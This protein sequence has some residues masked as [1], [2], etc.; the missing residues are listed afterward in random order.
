MKLV[1]DNGGGQ[2]HVL[3][4]ISW[5]VYERMN[6]GGKENS[7]SAPND[8]LYLLKQT[9]FGTCQEGQASRDGQAF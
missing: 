4:L 6:R 9:T 2:G 7:P 5:G 1:R 8:T 3:P